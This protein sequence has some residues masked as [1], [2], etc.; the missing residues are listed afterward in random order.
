MNQVYINQG[1]LPLGLDTEHGYID[2]GRELFM[3]ANTQSYYIVQLVPVS[4]VHR[5]MPGLDRVSRL[6]KPLAVIFTFYP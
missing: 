6:R 2:I 3:W 5:R 4:L 1:R